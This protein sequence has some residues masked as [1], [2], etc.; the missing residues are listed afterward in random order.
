[1]KALKDTT[2]I[3]LFINILTDTGGLTGTGGSS[4]NIDLPTDR[5]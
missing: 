4:I 2:I 3:I 5:E 1:M